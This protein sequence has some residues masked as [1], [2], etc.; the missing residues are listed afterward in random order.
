MR[1][2]QQYTRFG[3]LAALDAVVSFAGGAVDVT[4]GC[5]CSAF[6]V[7]VDAPTI[8]AMLLGLLPLSPPFLPTTTNKNPSPPPL[9][10]NSV[11]AAARRAQ[12]QQPHIATARRILVGRRRI[13]GNNKHDDD[14]LDMDDDDDDDTAA[15][16]AAAAER[17]RLLRGELAIGNKDGERVVG[18]GRQRRRWGRRRHG[19]G[20]RASVRSKPA[21]GYPEGVKRL[22]NPGGFPGTASVKRNPDVTA[23][24]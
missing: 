17:Q 3:I 21:P 23:L 1:H 10:R 14:A 5:P 9:R 20:R 24:E 19:A 4:T 6:H 18:H 8:T 13:D 2:P 11:D 15:A 16:A 12:Q 7:V 22:W